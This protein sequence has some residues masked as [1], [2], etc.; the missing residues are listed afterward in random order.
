MPAYFAELFPTEVRA[1]GIGVPYSSMVAIFGGEAPY[2]LTWLEGRAP[3]GCSLYMVILLIVG[4]A[5]TL[6][7]PETKG[8]RW[9]RSSSRLIFP[10]YSLRSTSIGTRHSYVV[11]KLRRKQIFVAA[12]LSKMLRCSAFRRGPQ[13][14]T[15]RF[16]CRS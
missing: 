4:L 5:T 9:C 2:T 1:S 15:L 6:L 11:D 10:S 8:K 3:H 7:S 16:G 12:T 14:R 13:R